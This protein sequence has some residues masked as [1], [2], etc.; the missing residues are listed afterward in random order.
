MS[1]YIIAIGGTGAKFVEAV[2]HLAFAG[3]YAQTNRVENLQILIVDPDTGNGNIVAAYSTTLDRYQQCA[4]ILRG[5][6][7]QNLSWW[8][9]SQVNKFSSGLLSP[10]NKNGKTLK[11]QLQIGNYHQNS[12][13]RQLIDVLYTQ[14]EQNLT[15][16]E[17]FRGRPVIGAAIMAQMAQKE[18]SPAIWRELIE[19]ITREANSEVSPQIFLCGSIFGGTGAAGFPTLGRLLVN[20]LAPV[21]HRVK[22]GGLLMLPYFKFKPPS[23]GEIYARPEEFLLKTESALHYYKEKV[24][25]LKFDRLYTLGLPTYT[26]VKNESTGGN[27]QRNPPH[28]LEVLGG[29]ALRNFI[30]QPKP[31]QTTFVDLS[32]RDENRMT[33]ED[34]PHQGD[35]VEV[36]DKMINSARFAFAWLSTIA[37]EL[38]HAKDYPRDITWVRKFFPKNQIIAMKEKTHPENAKLKTISDWCEDHLRW[39]FALHELDNSEVTWFNTNAFAVDGYSK[40]I[41][42]REDFGNL[43]SENGGTP[44]NKVLRTLS[45]TGL[46]PPDNTETAALAKSLYRSISS[47]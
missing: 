34:V 5:G 38:E 42:A 41:V 19:Q 12:A 45:K 43:I 27:N 29:L 22:L 25:E 35:R 33:W 23:E 40:V 24:A 14:A 21:L 15:L 32:R 37:P 6:I 10:F 16:E 26:M 46:N 30:F 9:G 39:L 31:Q 11:E 18:K 47:H 1:T 17:G 8:M 7:D 28:F 20:D 4:Q 44:I 2:I 13:T 36:R 3:I